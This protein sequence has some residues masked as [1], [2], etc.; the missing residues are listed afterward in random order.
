MPNLIVYVPMLLS[1]L[2]LMCFFKLAARMRRIALTWLDCALCALALGVASA[3]AQ[4]SALMPGGYVGTVLG[5]LISVG[6]GAWYFHL[7]ARRTD[8]QPL[9]WSDAVKMSALAFAMLSALALLAGGALL[10]VLG[11]FPVRVA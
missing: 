3:A 10:L 1:P 4:F 2:L 6:A 9:T 11:F 5:F 8:G 7:R